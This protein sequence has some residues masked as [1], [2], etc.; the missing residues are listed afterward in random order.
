MHVFPSPFLSF[1]PLHTTKPILPLSSSPSLQYCNCWSSFI[2][3]HESGPWQLVSATMF[4]L[5]SSLSLLISWFSFTWINPDF[6]LY[7]FSFSY[8]DMEINHH[9]LFSCHVCSA[10]VCVYLSTSPPWSYAPFPLSFDVISLHFKVI[11]FM[12]PCLPA[13]TYPFPSPPSPSLK[14]MSLLACLLAPRLQ[15]PS[16]GTVLGLS[17]CVYHSYCYGTTSTEQVSRLHYEPR[18]KWREEHSSHFKIS[19]CP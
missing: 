8:F 13:I 7:H 6:I 19:W 17:T 5:F 11:I 4:A 14:D 1:F 12:W 3:D 9:I 15:F 16:S 18:K 2:T 10:Y